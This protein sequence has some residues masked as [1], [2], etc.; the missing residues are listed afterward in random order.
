MD[1][2][3]HRFVAFLLMLGLCFAQVTG[4]TAACP[5]LPAGSA[6]PAMPAMHEG[7][8]GHHAAAAQPARVPVDTALCELHCQTAATVPASPAP[9][10]GIVGGTPLLVPAFLPASAAAGNDAARLSRPTMATA[11][12]VSIRYCR[13]QV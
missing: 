9:P 11:P 6:A 10:V 1:R 8:S 5:L 3:I 13:F 2:R 4:A 7:C 12:P